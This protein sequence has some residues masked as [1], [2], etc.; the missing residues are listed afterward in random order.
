ME[1]DY[2]NSQVDR[3]AKNIDDVCIY[4]KRIDIQMANMLDTLSKINAKMEA[5]TK[6]YN[7]E[8]KE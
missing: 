4:L 5:M 3:I 6:N 2:L 1:S 7:E 8:K